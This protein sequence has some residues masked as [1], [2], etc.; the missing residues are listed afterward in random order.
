MKNLIK[1]FLCYVLLVSF[2]FCSFVNRTTLS[3][4]ASGEYD[5]VNITEEESLQF[6]ENYD[7]DIPNK[8]RDYLDIG[9]VVKGL[10]QLVY[11]NPSYD[12]VFNYDEMQNFANEI[13]DNVI[14]YL[15]NQN[16][17]LSA[18]SS[19]SLQYN[20]VKDSNDNWVRQGG[21]WY[22]KWKNYNCYAY[23]IN[24]VEQP[25]FYPSGDYIQYQPGDMSGSGNFGTANSISQLANV[26]KDDL[27]KM[28]YTNIVLSTTIPN[29]TN[30]QELICIRMSKYDYHFMKYDL[31]TNSWYHKPGSSAVLKYNSTPNNSEKWY[32][33]YSAY[34]K[35]GKIKINI[36]TQLYYDSNI[37]FIRYDKNKVDIP[38]S[39]SNLSYNLGVQTGKDSI[40]EINN[41]SYNKYYEFNMN[42]TSAIKIELYDN[43]MELIES[44][45]GENVMFYK[46][47]LNETYYLKLNYISKSSSGNININISAHS[48][49]Y[50]MYEQASFGHLATCYCGYTTTLSHV[51]DDHYCIHCNAYTTTHDYHEPYTWVDYNQHLATCGCGAT[52][53]QGHAVSSN[54]FS[55]GKRYATCLFC[56]GLAERGFVQLNALS[57]EVKYVTNNGSYIL[58]NG[59]IVLVDE[60]I[61]LYLNCTLEFHKKD[62]Q[63][64][65][66]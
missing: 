55:W 22:N 47:L 44:Y 63:L 64:L 27:I 1:K 35:E 58:P 2:G 32:G 56:G 30:E 53:K 50:T 43:E 14:C 11:N 19:Y 48:H 9:S 16:T 4:C 41:L 26:V 29:V 36:F 6:L 62:S 42:A 12:F 39:A 60:D 10:I 15:N 59:V 51:Y 65:I 40:L 18:C 34:G 66:E 25:Q 20:T 28:G 46:P 8:F 49:T 13:K 52:A 45:T 5:F 24:R 33:E 54:A 61:E 31:S 21:A 23:A 57:A 37:Y 17:S 7:I 38:S 3:V